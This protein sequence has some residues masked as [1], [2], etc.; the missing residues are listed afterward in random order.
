M[1]QFLIGIGVKLGSKRRL[2]NKNIV[3]S[4]VSGY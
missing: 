3:N 2:N 4:S 1:T